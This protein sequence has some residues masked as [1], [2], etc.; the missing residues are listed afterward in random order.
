MSKPRILALDGLRGAAVVAMI[1]YH[2]SWDLS[3]FGHVGWNVSQDPLWKLFAASIAGTFLFVAGISLS[4]AHRQA[5]RWRAFLH[6]EA[7][8]V[9]AALAVSVATYFAF[10]SSFVRFGILHAIAAASLIALPFTQLPAAIALLA[11]IFTATL[12]LWASGPAF[13]G[14]WLLWT[15]LGQPLY[16]A[17]D[18]VPLAPW[19]ALTLFGVAV[20]TKI[21]G[22]AETPWLSGSAWG[23]AIGTRLCLLGRHSLAIY[24]LHQPLLYGL[25]WA[26]SATGLTPDRS[27]AIF[28]RDCTSSCTSTFGDEAVCRASCECTTGKLQEQGVW[29]DLVANAQD[30]DLRLALNETYSQCLRQTPPDPASD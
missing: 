22:K 14:Q 6:R 15:G 20:G 1:V 23:N 18:Y 13:D 28:V 2:F 11:A 25:V 27:V 16:G 5:I 9:T 7:I 30:P 10:Q 12:P 26:V 19:S 3:W 29:A 21:A 17:V 24:L 4:L 8:I